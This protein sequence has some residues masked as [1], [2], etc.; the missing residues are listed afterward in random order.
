M[1]SSP[2]LLPLSSSAG[3]PLPV[4]NSSPLNLSS[5]P[6]PSLSPVQS[7]PSLLPPVKSSPVFSSSPVVMSLPV[8]STSPSLVAP[9]SL[10]SGRT[11]PTASPAGSP[12]V[13][14]PLQFSSDTSVLPMSSPKLSPMLETN[15]AEFKSVDNKLTQ[16]APDSPSTLSFEDYSGPIAN[17]QIEKQL[18]DAG[19]LPLDKILTKD[20]FGNLMCN[21]IKATDATGRGVFV[22]LDCEGMVAVSPDD[23]VLSSAASASVVPYS[24]KMGTYECASSDVCG[25]AFECDNE[26]CTLKRGANGLTPK[27]TVF[28]HSKTAHHG[29][30]GVLDGHPIAYPIVRMSEIMQN[31]EAVACSIKASHDR[32]RNT[33]FSSAAKDTQ[34]LAQASSDLHTHVKRYQKGQHYVSSTLSSTI[35][36]LEKLDR[37]YKQ[38]PPSS[39]IEKNNHRLI[40]YN[41]RRRHDLVMDHIKISEA[42]NNRLN[43]IKE[44]SQEIAELNDYSNSLFKD[45]HLMKTE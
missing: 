8:I 35:A 43:R 36:D 34:E 22:E 42:V 21:Y 32:M 10:S 31:P 12:A 9:I 20:N 17:M 33:E 7:S 19:Y 25:V 29:H 6:V 23:V 28:S 1:S 24:V 15:T 3:S 4:I 39:D 14:V 37:K 16:V 26:I 27:E 30:H 5:A 13:L 40:H 44:L 45:I 2:S 41:L 18:V 11:S 38:D